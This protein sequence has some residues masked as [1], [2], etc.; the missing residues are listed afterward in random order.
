LLRRELYRKKVKEA[1][2]T[3]IS[4]KPVIDEQSGYKMY[5]RLYYVR[6]ADDYLIAI[7]GPKW[8]AKDVMKKTQ[9]FL[10]SNLHFSLIG[11]NLVHSA[12][13]SVRFLG[14]DIKIPKRDE[15][16]VVETR[17]ILS[18]K[19][20]RNRLLNRKKVMVERYENS[21]LKIYESEKRKMLKALANSAIN[22]NEKLKS[23]KEIARKDALDQINIR[24][25]LG[26][27]GAEQYKALLNKERFQLE[28]S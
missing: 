1:I 5:Y 19:K 22:K 20:I 2:K 15:R 3:G 21:L 24:A 9:D 28:S 4:Q 13:N 17:K 25:T 6:Y 11:G 26:D 23:I 10:K 12:Y 8:F 16:R 14:F 18:F 7:K 27:S